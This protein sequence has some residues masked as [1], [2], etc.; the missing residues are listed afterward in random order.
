[1]GAQIA[2]VA[3]LIG[4]IVAAIEMTGLGIDLGAALVNLAQGSLALLLIFTLVTATILG[5]GL[6]TIAAY[7]LTATVL[8]PALIQIG[9]PLITAHLFPFVFAVFAHLTPPIGIGLIVATKMAGGHYWRTA[10][11]ALKA[12]MVAFVVPFFFVYAPSIILETKGIAVPNIVMQFVAVIAAVVALQVVVSNYCFTVIKPYE[13]LLFSVAALLPLIFIFSSQAYY[14]FL[15]AIVGV[16]LL[17]FAGGM[18]L[19][20]SRRHSVLA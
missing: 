19:M 6:P 16:G 3:G 17:V 14:F 13:R 10:R 7:I 4:V 18:N 1:M 2:V 9:L 11:E 12:A 8:S 20:R 5:M 15:M